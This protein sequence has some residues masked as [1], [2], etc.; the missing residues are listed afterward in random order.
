MSDDPE[1]KGEEKEQTLLSHLVE[2]RERL[3]HSIVAVLVV[4]LCLAL[5]AS[6]I[7][8]LIASPLLSQAAAD[9]AGNMIATEVTSPFLVPFKL[10]IFVAIYICVPYILYQ[11]WSFVVPGLYDTE[12][13]LMYPLMLSSIILFYLGTC[14]AFFVVF[15]ILFEYI[16]KFTPEGVV[17]MPD[18]THYMNFILKLFFAFGMAFEVP[19]ATIL[20]AKAGIMSIESMAEKRPYIIVGAFCIG[21]LL[22]PPDPISQSLLAVPIW[23]LFEAGLFMAKYFVDDE[24]LEDEDE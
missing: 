11:A 9:S 10:T 23:L 24:E 17:Y 3:L 1:I 16:P 7:Y 4:F 18:I 6:D 13:S 14:F 5:F 22:T 19:I 20:F 21:M 2:L 12:R 8:E 15:P